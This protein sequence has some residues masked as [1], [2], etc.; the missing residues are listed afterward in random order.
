MRKFQKFECFQGGEN[1]NL[2]IFFVHNEK[3]GWYNKIGGC[4]LMLPH[5]CEIN[6]YL[7][8][9]KNYS[10]DTSQD[11]LRNKSDSLKRMA[12]E[13]KIPKQLF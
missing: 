8:H 4:K 10:I 1:K 11:Y 7:V 12:D 2:F 13:P 5:C 6:Q 3:S 9:E